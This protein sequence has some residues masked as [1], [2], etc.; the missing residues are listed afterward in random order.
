MLDILE[1]RMFKPV[2][3]GYIFQPP[4][5]IFT[6]TNAYHVNE[7]QK[8]EILT[9]MRAH[10]A[11]LQRTVTFGALVSH[12]HWCLDRRG[13]RGTPIRY[14]SHRAVRR[15]LYTDNQYVFGIPL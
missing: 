13:W 7:A 1:A 4:P 11:R 12:H 15:F 5:T 10:G 8:A 14:H 6:R 2:P 9:I 3:D